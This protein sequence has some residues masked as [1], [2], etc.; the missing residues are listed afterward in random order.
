MDGPLQNLLWAEEGPDPEQPEAQQHPR[1]RREEKE[2]PGPAAQSAPVL[3]GGQLP[4][5]IKRGL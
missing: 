3:G 1:K 2:K 5:Q 4:A